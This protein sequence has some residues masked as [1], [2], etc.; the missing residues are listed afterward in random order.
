MGAQSKE[1]ALPPW[2]YAV[3]GAFGAV[4]ANT[5]VYPLD[6]YVLSRDS[7][8]DDLKFPLQLSKI[9]PWLTTRCAASQNQN[10]SPSPGEA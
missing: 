4:V 2:G 8:S 10:S 1:A 5:L 7:I 6:M 9:K 3:A